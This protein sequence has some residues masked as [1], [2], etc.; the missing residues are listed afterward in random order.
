MILLDTTIML[1][2]VAESEYAASFFEWK[3]IKKIRIHTFAK[4]EMAFMKGYTDDGTT[5]EPP[6]RS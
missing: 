2:G 1:T 5:E 4:S 6:L 3:V